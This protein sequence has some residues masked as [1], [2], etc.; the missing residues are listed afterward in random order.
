MSQERPTLKNPIKIGP[1]IGIVILLVIANGCYSSHRE[2][3][4]EIKYIPL[5]EAMMKDNTVAVAKV[6]PTYKEVTIKVMGLPMK[7]YEVTY[8]YDV[9][10]GG[11]YKGERT[12]SSPP[13]SAEMP[14]YY[15]KSDPSYSSFEPQEDIKRITERSSSNS[16]LYWCIGLYVVAVLAL[17]GYISEALNYL[18]AKKAIR[19]AENAAYQ[20]ATNY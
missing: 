15:A 19:D 16:N 10:G 4:N 17:F 13:T 8:T 2:R 1:I 11:P 18:K 6:D 5:L 20:K 14:L 9:N 3:K 7:H 12:L